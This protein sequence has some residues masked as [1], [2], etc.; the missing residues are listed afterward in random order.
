MP[1]TWCLA[2]R[3][4]FVLHTFSMCM[5]YFH[6]SINLN[7]LNVNPSFGYI[8]RRIVANQVMCNDA[9]HTKSGWLWLRQVRMLG[10]HR[11]GHQPMLGRLSAPTAAEPEN[12]P[13][14]NWFIAMMIRLRSA[15]VCTPSC[16][17]SLAVSIL[18]VSMSTS[19]LT[20]SSKGVAVKRK[21]L[22]ISLISVGLL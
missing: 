18:K 4:I 13:D 8:D 12:L 7:A 10:L 22:F 9:L 21:R 16:F 5:R 1:A 20:N 15:N 6:L 19:C 11:L 3:Q 17:K 14:F 2:P